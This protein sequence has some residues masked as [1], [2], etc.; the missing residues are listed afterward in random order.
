MTNTTKKKK[1]TSKTIGNRYETRIAKLLSDW[2]FDDSISIIRSITSGAL[3]DSKVSYNGDLIPIGEKVYNIFKQWPFLIECKT[4]YEKDTATFQNYSI[5]KQWI[6]KLNKE[7]TDKQ[8]ILL[9]I[10]RFGGSNSRELLI[11]NYKFNIE[12]D[13]LFKVDNSYYYCYGF[14]E[15][16]DFELDS[17]FSKSDKSIYFK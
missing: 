2:I 16:L 5:L 13:I 8:Q 14:K 10:V 1:P 17:L 3:K 4:G 7:K 12:P 11:S 6:V 15:I 9:L